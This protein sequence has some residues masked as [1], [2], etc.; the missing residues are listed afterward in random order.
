MKLSMK[1]RPQQ[2]PLKEIWYDMNLDP[3]EI[4]NLRTQSSKNIGCQKMFLDGWTKIFCLSYLSKS[5]SFEDYPIQYQKKYNHEI[6]INE[7]VTARSL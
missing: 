4:S 6:I 1:G 7:I 5:C 2:D 3:F